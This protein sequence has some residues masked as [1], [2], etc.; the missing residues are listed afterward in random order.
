ML[1]SLGL[2]IRKGLQV[3][4]QFLA[5]GLHVQT[6]DSNDNAVE[7]AHLGYDNG[8]DSGGGTSKA[9]YYSL[10]TRLSG[11]TIGNYSMAE[12]EKNEASGYASHAEGRFTVASN[13]TSHSEGS[14]TIAQGQGSHAE[15]DATHAIGKYSHTEGLLTKANYDYQTIVGRYN[16]NKFNTVFEVGNG[17]DNS[18]RS[19]ALESYLNG[20]LKIAGSLFTSMADEF[21]KG[22]GANHVIIGGYHICFGRETI[23]HTAAGYKETEITLPHTYTNTPYCFAS[24]SNRPTGGAARTAYATHSSGQAGNKIYVGSYATGSV[25]AYVNWLTIGE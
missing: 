8:T 5:D 19:N 9:P 10:G 2:F 6:Y 14:G 22:S 24:Y 4:A 7:I 1:T 20:D 15:G 18:T 25:T 21:A 12:G 3:F 16:A 13:Y 23:S 11:S 17:T